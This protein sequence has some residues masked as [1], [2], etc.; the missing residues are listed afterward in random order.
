MRAKLEALRVCLNTYTPR[1]KAVIPF[2][3]PDIS[4]PAQRI[5]KGPK[6]FVFI[7]VPLSLKLI[8]SLK[9]Q[10]KTVFL[11]PVVE[12]I[13]AAYL[14]KGEVDCSEQGVILNLQRFLFI[15]QV[16]GIDV[17]FDT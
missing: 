8:H 9:G 2:P 5:I 13:S 6:V 10:I 3:R 11:I 14:Q 15:G 1:A 16:E 12:G 7:V 17:I 4:W